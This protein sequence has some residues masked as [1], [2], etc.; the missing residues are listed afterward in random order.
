MSKK[1]IILMPLAVV[2]LGLTSCNNGKRLNFNEAAKICYNYGV[3]QDSLFSD[4]LFN[5]AVQTFKVN[6]KSTRDVTLNKANLKGSA[7]S[8]IQLNFKS[9]ESA[10]ANVKLDVENVEL[11]NLN[12]SFTNTKSNSSGETE[13][14][15]NFDYSSYNNLSRKDGKLTCDA[16]YIDNLS[17]IGS[18]IEGGSVGEEF[19]EYAKQIYQDGDL[20]LTGGDAI[21]AVYS[22][23]LINNLLKSKAPSSIRDNS[24]YK[25]EFLEELYN[26]IFVSSGYSKS[27]TFTSSNDQSIHGKLSCHINTLLPKDVYQALGISAFINSLYYSNYI[28]TSVINVNDIKF[29]FEFDIKDY[30]PVSFAINYE[31]DGTFTGYPLKEKFNHTQTF[32][33]N[34]NVKSNINSLDGY[35]IIEQKD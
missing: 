33:Y 14:N 5:T 13:T 30:F 20:S 23:S 17:K 22:S 25:F 24:V 34:S 18:K 1:K 4:N 12:N 28:T 19:L 21:L 6:S 31:M 15:Y 35:T 2:A 10:C 3:F 27:C 9:V 32:T 11:M 16:Y 29:S 26:L 8:D 7:T